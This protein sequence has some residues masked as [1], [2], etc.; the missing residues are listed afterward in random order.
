MHGVQ[1]LQ[2]QRVLCTPATLNRACVV[3]YLRQMR[4]KIASG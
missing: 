4:R 3:S 1:H 2:A